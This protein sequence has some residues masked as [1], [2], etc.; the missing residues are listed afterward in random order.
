[1]R[2][3]TPFQ[4][5]YRDTAARHDCILVDGQALFHAIGPHGLLNDYLFHDAMHPSLRGYIALAQAILESMHARRAFGWAAGAPMPAIEPSLCATHFGLKPQDWKPLCERGFMFYHMTAALR[6]DPSPAPHQETRVQKRRRADR[7]RRAR[8]SG[9]STQYWRPG[10][11]SG[12]AA[13]HR[14]CRSGT[15]A[16][17]SPRWPEPPRPGS[18]GSIK[19][20]S[21]AATIPITSRRPPPSST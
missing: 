16:R 18:R 15:L 17:L 6:Y 14:L 7:A 9:R 8:R 4:Q 12:P 3:L 2:C 20:R 1:M 10:G 13:P 21:S 19:S 11:N 5:A